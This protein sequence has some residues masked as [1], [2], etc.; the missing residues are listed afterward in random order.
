MSFKAGGLS[1]MTSLFEIKE[2]KNLTGN[3][4]LSPIEAKIEVVTCHHNEITF[5]IE[6]AKCALD[7]LISLTAKIQINKALFDFEATGKI[8]ELTPLENNSFRI[9]I[10]MTQFDKK[11]WQKFIDNLHKTQGRADKILAAMKDEDS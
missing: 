7:H 2:I 9:K 11:V 8:I 10:R 5:F 1:S 6:K 4:P 3:A